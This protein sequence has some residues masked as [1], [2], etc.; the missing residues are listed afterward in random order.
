MFIYPKGDWSVASKPTEQEDDGEDRVKRGTVQQM[1]NG[2]RSW[3][4]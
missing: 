1:R 4:R 2:D 3:E